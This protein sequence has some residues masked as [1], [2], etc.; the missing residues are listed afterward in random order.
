MSDTSA[1]TDIE[2]VV[3]GF[4]FSYAK[5]LDNYPRYL[6]HACRC[7]Q[8]FNVYDGNIVTTAKV[9]VDSTLKC[10]VMPDDMIGFVDLVTPINGS[11]WS[12]TEKD[13][14][15]NTTTFTGLVEG[16]DTTQG[17]GTVIDQPRITSYGGKG[18]YNQF[19]FK[20]D[21][22]ARRIYYDNVLTENVV[23][24]YVSSGI[25]ATGTTV[26]PVIIVSM[27]E[28]YLLWKESYWLPEFTRERQ[29]R[30]ADFWKEK[31]KVRGL[32]NSMSEA[33]WRDLILSTSTQTIQR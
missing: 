3:T 18:G 6:Q 4:I 29:M 22:K 19:R 23:L 33:Q 11:W 20:F 5:S 26:V 13:K 30:E 28:N 31:M 7:V 14:I 16:R 15:V 27:I 17:E 2:K 9:T 32:I 25:N 12:F 10:I 8:D 24:I 1:L 21:W